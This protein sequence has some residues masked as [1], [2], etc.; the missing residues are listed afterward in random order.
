MTLLSSRSVAATLAATTILG[1]ALDLAGFSPTVFAVGV[2]ASLVV[3]LAQWCSWYFA[4]ASGLILFLGADAV[5]VRFFAMVPGTLDVKNL[6]VFG[7]LGVTI[8]LTIWRKSRLIRWPRRTSLIAA[9]VALGPLVAGV[10]TLVAIEATTSATRIAWAMNNDAVWN[11]MTAR[12]VVADGGVN[13]S[14]HA[15][16]APLTAALLGS[17]F[18]PGRGSASAGATLAHDVSREAE[19]LL[20]AMLVGAILAGLICLAALG[21]VSLWLRIPAAFAVA[22]IPA[23]WFVAGNAFNLGFYNVGPAVILL[24]GSWLV[25]SETRDRPELTLGVLGV[26]A[27]ALLATWAPLALVP[28]G[29]AVAVSFSRIKAIAKVRSIR[30]AGA[31][32]LGP[33]ILMLYVL[34]VTLPDL[35]R[36]GGALAGNGA[37]FNY[38]FVNAASV[39]VVA[40]AVVGFG[41]LRRHRVSDFHGLVAVILSA[42]IA[43]TYLVVQRVASSA[44]PWGYYPQKFCWLIAILVIVI[45]ATSLGSWLVAPRQR[46]FRSLGIVGLTACATFAM[47]AQNPPTLSNVLPF[48]YILKG[49]VDLSRASGAV[50]A[51]GSV[52]QKNIVASYERNGASDLFI[53]GWLLQLHAASSKDP[54]RNYAYTADGKHLDNVC[55]AIRVWGGGVVVHT[56]DPNLRTRLYDACTGK[57]FDVEVRHG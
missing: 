40:L 39:A 8:D 14:A 43:L 15:N 9:V 18:G 23:T 51:L 27:V 49:N 47:L 53:N 28:V 48:G 30:G 13:E 44:T 56:S 34:F 3:L 25:W 57:R 31:W 17:M 33:I 38:R 4:V 37:F 54:V 41:R 10:A 19:L 35:R 7:V 5:L 36:D 6:I 20:W 26:A 22:C 52:N 45:A 50:F 1:V 55:E 21:S 29:L 32:L 2:L 46:W 16:P 11:T 24:L 12:F 42:G